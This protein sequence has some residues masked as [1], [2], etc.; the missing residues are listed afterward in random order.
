MASRCC[1][2]VE[3]VLSPSTASTYV[4][5]LEWHRPPASS[6]R[7]SCDGVS[8]EGKINNSSPLVLVKEVRDQMD[9][10]VEMSNRQ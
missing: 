6:T 3:E 2:F 4:G 7:K 1:K 5:L 10:T 8:F 9:I